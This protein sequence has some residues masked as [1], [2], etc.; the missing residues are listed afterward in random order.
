MNVVCEAAAGAQP[1]G[2]WSCLFIVKLKVCDEG[3][4]RAAHEVT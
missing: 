2:L 3:K 4:P 1:P